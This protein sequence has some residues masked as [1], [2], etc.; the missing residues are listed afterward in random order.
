MT[1]DNN[2]NYGIAYDY[3]SVMHYFPEYV[4]PSCSWCRERR[5]QYILALSTLS[6][7]DFATDPTRP[8]IYALN[9]AYQLSIGSHELPTFADIVM[10]NSHY[11]CYG[12]RT[13]LSTR[14]QLNQFLQSLRTVLVFFIQKYIN[15]GLMKS[16]ASLAYEAFYTLEIGLQ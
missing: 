16:L 11:A 6:F 2:Y 9:P 14:Y 10:M 8:V 13:K 15:N 4:L 12:R 3:R 1:T 7:R 5:V